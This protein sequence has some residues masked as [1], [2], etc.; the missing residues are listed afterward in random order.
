MRFLEAW[1]RV[2]QL[3]EHNDQVALSAITTGK[4]VSEDFWDNFILVCN[5]KE[6]L[7]ELLDVSPEKVATWSI[8]IK[9]KMDHVEPEEVNHKKTSL[10]NTGGGNLISYKQWKEN[11]GG[12]GEASPTP[13]NPNEPSRTRSSS[14]SNSLSKPFWLSYKNKNEKSNSATNKERL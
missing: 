6:G 9:Q 14:M 2:R 12:V 4:N 5:N 8:K 7:A 11:L 3:V 1:D 13:V 10:I